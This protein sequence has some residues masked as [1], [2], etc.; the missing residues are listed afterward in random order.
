[1][2]DIFSKKSYTF[3]VSLS[4]LL[5]G[6]AGAVLRKTAGCLGL[7]PYRANITPTKL[8]LCFS[9]Y[10]LFFFNISSTKTQYIGV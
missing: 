3:Q 8:A 1:M 6:V 5:R 9:I 7:A 2:Y 10:G 4:C